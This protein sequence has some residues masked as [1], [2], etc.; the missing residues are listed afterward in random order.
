MAELLINFKYSITALYE[1]LIFLVILLLS[2]I[3]A[4][5]VDFEMIEYQENLNSE[6]KYQL[7]DPVSF[8]YFDFFPNQN[9]MIL[10]KFV[11]TTSLQSNQTET[12]TEEYLRQKR[13]ADQLSIALDDIRRIEEIEILI[14]QNPKESNLKFEQI[15]K[16]FSQI[17]NLHLSKHIMLSIYT[18]F[19]QDLE[20]HLAIT[21]QRLA[22]L[23]LNAKHF[24][25]VQNSDWFHTLLKKKSFKNLP[26][27]MIN[28]RG[29]KILS[30]TKL[31]DI[32][33][34]RCQDLLTTR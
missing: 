19:A 27:S 5:A 8:S 21:A 26:H 10:R 6:F 7:A 13:I 12:T 29:Y 20:S 9:K 2:S 14:Q 4:H 24:K 31:D 17:K 16:L 32:K 1:K 3:S 18:A 34:L 25:S 30:K 11:V 28:Y 22:E 33:L 15:A 23:G